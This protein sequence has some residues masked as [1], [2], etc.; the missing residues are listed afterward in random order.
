[1][2]ASEVTMIEGLKDKIKTPYVFTYLWVFLTVN[3]EN[4]LILFYEPKLISVKLKHLEWDVLIPVLVT[5]ALL[6][7]SP[8]IN[9]FLEVWGKFALRTLE[10]WSNR[11][12]KV[13]VITYDQYEIKKQEL[14]RAIQSRAE[15]SDRYTKQSESFHESLANLESLKRTTQS[16]EQSNEE[17][18]QIELNLKNRLKLSAESNESLKNEYSKLEA[19]HKTT[20]HQLEHLKTESGNYEDKFEK[21]ENKLKRLEIEN[22]RLESELSIKIE[23]INK[24]ESQIE[25][26]QFEIKDAEDKREHFRANYEKASSKSNVELQ[27]N[28]MLTK[29]ME[30]KERYIEKLETKNEQALDKI[31]EL[32]LKVT[33]LGDKNELLQ[34]LYDA[35]SE[36]ENGALEALEMVSD[37]FSKITNIDVNKSD[38]LSQF[39]KSSIQ[40][41]QKKLQDNNK[42]AS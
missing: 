4:V 5:I 21:N 9:K 13:K 30:E 12:G 15:L 40:L 32:S 3:I 39:K 38:E 22:S 10:A 24:F 20:R 37:L 29:R 17:Y 41:V 11:V 35:S 36:G 1:M 42:R 33:L 25:A 8:Y 18:G 26:L 7:A 31:K 6:L 2:E 27:E 16:L 19:L 34:S 14:D 28:L 23:L